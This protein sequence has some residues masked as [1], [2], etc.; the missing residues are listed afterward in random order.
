MSEMAT[1]TRVRTRPILF[2][3]ARSLASMTL[4]GSWVSRRV[5]WVRDL[6]LCASLAYS[7]STSASIWE[8]LG[9]PEYGFTMSMGEDNSAAYFGKTIN[10]GL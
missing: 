7:Q 8:R 6:R 2:S 10:P 3:R 4:S 5:F 9:W 1:R